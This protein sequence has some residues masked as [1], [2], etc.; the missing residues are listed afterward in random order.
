MKAFR[1]CLISAVL[2]AQT[3]IIGPAVAVD[4]SPVGRP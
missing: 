3:T 4:S 1:A 2:I